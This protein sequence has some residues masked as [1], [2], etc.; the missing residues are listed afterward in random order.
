MLLSGVSGYAKNAALS[1]LRMQ[2]GAPARDPE[3][4][5][6]QEQ[7]SQANR[8]AWEGGREGVADDAAEAANLHKV[9][10]GAI[11]I[12]RLGI[13]SNPWQA[14]LETHTP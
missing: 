1:T 4:C 14:N 3:L 10:P 2:G 5:G 7:R 12:G 8:G 13:Y 6:N 11:S 9:L